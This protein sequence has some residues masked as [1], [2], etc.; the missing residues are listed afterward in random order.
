MKVEDWSRAYRTS[1][2]EAGKSE[3][4]PRISEMSGTYPLGTRIMENLAEMGVPGIKA[5]KKRQ[6]VRDDLGSAYNP[7][8]KVGVLVKCL[9][10]LQMI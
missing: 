8:V 7:K 1:R 5:D 2:A 9:A 3:D 4:A 6:Q 10:L